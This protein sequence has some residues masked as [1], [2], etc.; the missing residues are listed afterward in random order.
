MFFVPRFLSFFGI[1]NA[2]R[3]Q[4][5]DRDILFLVHTKEGVF[6]RICTKSAIWVPE[7]CDEGSFDLKADLSLGK[8]G[9]LL[10]LLKLLLGLPE[11]GQVEG[12]D[13]LGL[14]DLLL[15]SLDLGLQL[16]GEV[17]HPVL[18]LLVL[19]N[20]EGE[21][22]GTTLGLLVALGVLAGVGLH[23]AQ[24]NL[25]L[26]DPGLQLGHGGAA[27]TDGVL[28]GI[29]ELLLELGQ[30]GLEGALGLGLGVGV[31][32]LS[33]ELVGKTG[34]INHGLLGLLLRVLGL[35]EH[36]VDLS[37]HGV[38][39]ALDGPLVA[40]GLGV[41]GGH[42]V[43]GGARLGELGLGLALAPLGRV[44]QGASLLHLSS[45]S[46][47]TT[48]SKGGPLNNLLPL[49]LLLLVGALG[50]PVLALVALD[51]LL[52]LRVGLVGVV[53]SDLE[54]VD[55]ALELLLDPQRLGLG[56]LLRLEAGLHGVHGA[57]VVLAAVL[58]LLFL[59]SNPAVDLL[60]DLAKLQ[61]GA[62]DLVLLLLEGSL[63][64]LQSSLKFLLLDLEPPPLLVQLVDG[65]ATIAKLVEQ[66]LDL[67]SKVLVLALHDI[68][69]LHSLVVACLQAE[70][71]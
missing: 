18:V 66:I 5:R 58:E 71:L 25:Q 23:V 7:Q 65:A 16:V 8:P 12:G 29:G 20:L 53:Q 70:H 63:S 36:V 59:L 33:T 14:L 30:L 52:G 15:V 45:K 37:V 13:L 50:L 1:F 27:T 32:L 17:A 2:R 9:A 54:L 55:V 64:L 62:E 44:E 38:H 34:S 10:G 21:L 40:G 43:D 26:A 57:R 47:G 69:L 11:L 49:P 31:I 61:R 42:L 6:E 3:G 48:V 46:I 68:Q 41:D 60:A 28:V 24:L 22:L 19:L 56:A 67:V 35:L 4:R 39:G 51:R